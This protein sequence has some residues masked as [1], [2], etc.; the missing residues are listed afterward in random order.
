MTWKRLNPDMTKRLSFTDRL[1]SMTT[2]EDE[3]SICDDCSR[4][5][6][7][8]TSTIVYGYDHN[9]L[10]LCPECYKEWEEVLND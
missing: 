6:D 9:P 5:F 8:N 7:F 3:K 1:L 4:E 10:I 2:E